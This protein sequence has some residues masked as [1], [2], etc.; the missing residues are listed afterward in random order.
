VGVH[1]APSADKHGI[2]REDAIY[3]IGH[4]AARASL[5]VRSGETTVV[6]VGHPHGQTERYIEVIV[7]LTP[8]RD[9]VIFHVMQLSDLYRHLIDEN[10]E[11]A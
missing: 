6:F 2:P 1:W 10:G 7:A 4:A 3:A 5:E 9:L 11:S 8:P